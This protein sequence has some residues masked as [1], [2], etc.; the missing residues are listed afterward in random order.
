MG[1]ADN[2]IKKFQNNVCQVNAS[3]NQCANNERSFYSRLLLMD[4]TENESKLALSLGRNK[5]KKVK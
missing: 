1:R 2:R 4:Q 3:K 5:K